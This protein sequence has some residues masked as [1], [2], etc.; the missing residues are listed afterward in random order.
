VTEPESSAASTPAG[1][2]RSV[3][4]HYEARLREHG[5]TARGMDWKDEQSQRLRFSVLCDVADLAGHSVYEVGAGAAH[6]CSY[7]QQRNPTASY[8]GCDLSGEMVEAA[9]RL[10]PGADIEVRDILVDPP[11][12]RFDFVVCSGAF[13]VKLDANDSD[14][15]AYLYDVIGRMYAMCDVAIAFN[16]MSDQVDY[17][18]ET[19]YYARPAEILEFCRS[20]LSRYVTLRH[21]Y[22]LYEFT[23]YVYR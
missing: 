20:E 5:A 17:R 2:K 23:T 8:S 3:V 7:L 10:H 14:W 6:L 19:L 12:R 21:D 11:Q 13:H 18:A 1:L 16:L 22:P 15:R 4:S 9:R